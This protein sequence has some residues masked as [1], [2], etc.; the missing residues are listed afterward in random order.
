M[1]TPKASPPDTYNGE[2]VKGSQE[3]FW[4]RYQDAGGDAMWAKL[5]GADAK[6]TLQERSE[7]LEVAVYHS[8]GGNQKVKSLSNTQRAAMERY[9]N[10]GGQAAWA[11]AGGGKATFGERLEKLERNAFMASGGDKQTDAKELSAIVERYLAV[12]G[13]AAW[14]K[15]GGK[16]TTHM[17]DRVLQMEQAEY[18]A[19][20]GDVAWLR[21]GLSD[22]NVSSKNLHT[23]ALF[24]QSL[25]GAEAVPLV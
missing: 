14:S 21:C 1:P 15:A 25:K 23:R 19:A 7:Q 16:A 20:G 12:G 17:R 13:D 11:K 3:V 8:W 4:D 2:Q 5:K 10:L 9:R 18:D 6:A 24:L 22:D